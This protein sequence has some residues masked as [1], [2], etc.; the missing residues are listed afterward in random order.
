M[1]YLAQGMLS[2]FTASYQLVA[3]FLINSLLVYR[4]FISRINKLILLYGA[5]ILVVTH[6]YRLDEP[7]K[8]CS[9]DYLT[10]EESQ[11]PL[12]TT[13]YLIAVGKLFW[14]Y[15]VGLWVMLSLACVCAAF[16]GFQVYNT[17]T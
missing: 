5:Y 8:I 16:I 17:F 4:H 6:I 3:I 1:S 12:V 2:F 7:G 9:G 14:A 13:N 11:D 10:R 15:M